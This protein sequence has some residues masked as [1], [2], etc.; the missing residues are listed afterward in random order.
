MYVCICHG[1]TDRA[2]RRAAA[3]GARS[4][5]DLTAMTGIASGCGS[6]ADLAREL[7]EESQELPL[8]VF[9][10]MPVAA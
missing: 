9:N 2:I 1:I 6:C 10:E 4:L 8:A 3:S 7:L 5:A